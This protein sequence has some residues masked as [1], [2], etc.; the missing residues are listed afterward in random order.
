MKSLD[1]T[2]PYVDNDGWEHTDQ[3]DI[4]TIHDYARTGKLLAKKTRTSRPSHHRFREATARALEFGAKYNGSPFVLT[5]F[6]GIA[7][8]IPA[9]RWRD[10]RVGL[11]RGRAHAARRSWPG[12]TD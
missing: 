3:T 4:M 1:V 10:E 12:S 6:G 7:Y 5:E 2:R 8:R 9:R 11:Q